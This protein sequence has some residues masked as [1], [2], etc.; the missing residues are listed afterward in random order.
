[1]ARPASTEPM[2]RLNLNI[3][4]QV[5]KRLERVRS[6]SGAKSITEVIIRALS[7]YEALLRTNDKIVV[8][9]TDGTERELLL[10]P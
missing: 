1:M 4:V 2:S 10:I 7:V 3:P 9:G 8:R 6:V 5:R